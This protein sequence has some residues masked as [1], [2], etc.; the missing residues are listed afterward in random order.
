M[1]L[2][3][4]SAGVETCERLLDGASKVSGASEDLFLL[5][6]SCLVAI[7]SSEAVRC[8]LRGLRPEL[9]CSVASLENM[10]E[11]GIKSGFGVGIQRRSDSPLICNHSLNARYNQAGLLSPLLTFK[12]VRLTNLKVATRLS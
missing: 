8:R 9:L 5:L 1:L 7:E 6:G 2:S 10:A 4:S 11:R 12:A 3:L